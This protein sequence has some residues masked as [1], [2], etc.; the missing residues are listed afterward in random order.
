[1]AEVD[2]GL[3]PETGGVGAHDEAGFDKA[4]LDEVCG[5]PVADEGGVGEGGGFAWALDAVDAGADAVCDELALAVSGLA[6]VGVVVAEAAGGGFERAAA[7]GVGF[8]ECERGW[9]ERRAG[10]DSA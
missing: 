3:E 1:M 6:E 4:V 9:F 2:R 8:F 10:A 5:G 7:C